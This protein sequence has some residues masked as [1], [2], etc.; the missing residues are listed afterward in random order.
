MVSSSHLHSHHSNEF[1]SIYTARFAVVRQP[2]LIV[3]LAD[4]KSADFGTGCVLCL[5]TVP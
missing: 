1:V 3:L 5:L 4:N 2:C